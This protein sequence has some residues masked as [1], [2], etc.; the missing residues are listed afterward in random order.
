MHYV[1]EPEM[2]FTHTAAPGLLIAAKH[3]LVSAQTGDSPLH[4]LLPLLVLTCIKQ[5]KKQQLLEFH[6]ENEVKM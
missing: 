3:Q 2:H 6:Y 5:K 1:K 4:D